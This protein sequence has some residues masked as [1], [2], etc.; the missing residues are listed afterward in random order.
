MS[1]NYKKI[2]T[3][4][5]AYKAVNVDYTKRPDFSGMPEEDREALAAHAD[6]LIV[7]KSL[8]GDWKPNWNS[9]EPKYYL[10]FDM[11]KTETNPSGFTLYYVYYHFTYSYVGSRFCFKSREIAEHAIKYFLPQYRAY[12]VIEQ[13]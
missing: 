13:K 3:V 6:L 12:F 1:V 10:W 2:T 5:A 7:H 9:N 4:E 8:N 11:E